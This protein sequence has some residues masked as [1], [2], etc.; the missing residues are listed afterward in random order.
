MN[1]IGEYFLEDITV[2]D[3]VIDF[4]NTSEF[5]LERRGPGTTSHGVNLHEKDS[6]DLSIM[7]PNLWDFPCIADYLNQLQEVC[8]KYIKEYKWCDAY[9]PWTI[10]EGLNIQYYR[11]G[12]GFKQWH[13]ERGRAEYPFSTRHLAFQTYLNDV[14]DGGETHFYYQDLKIKAQKGK[15]L[16]WPADWTHTHKGIVSNTEEKYIIT[17]WFN[18]EDN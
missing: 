15:T 9:S 2:C 11:P 3:R 16:I 14:T 10:T 6:M 5:S 4:Y 1:F 17:G 12:G 18:Y 7:R 13:T 8:G